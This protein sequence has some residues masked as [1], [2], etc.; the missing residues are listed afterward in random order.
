MACLACP[1]PWNIREKEW[2]RQSVNIAKDWGNHSSCL[3]ADCVISSDHVVKDCKPIEVIVRADFVLP[4]V[5]V[6]SNRVSSFQR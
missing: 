2:F 5:S 1:R 6:D 3:R 4:S